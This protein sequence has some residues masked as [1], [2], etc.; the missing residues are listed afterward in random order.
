MLNTD[1]L[2]RI[3]AFRMFIHFLPFFRYMVIEEGS[4]REPFSIHFFSPKDITCPVL[5]PGTCFPRV[6]IWARDRVCCML[7]EVGGWRPTQLSSPVEKA[8]VWLC[9]SFGSL[10]LYVISA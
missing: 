10:E 1:K 7:S 5:W 4:S 6:A 2:M 8:G 9:I 3:L